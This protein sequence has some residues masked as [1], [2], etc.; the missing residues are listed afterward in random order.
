VRLD[1]VARGAAP[2]VV[3]LRLPAPEGARELRARVDGAGRALGADRVVAVRLDRPRVVDVSWTGGL[4]VEPPAVDLQPG[5][6]DG[7]LRILSFSA[8]ADGWRL[9]VEGR[10]GTTAVV[11]LHGRRPSSAAG[12]T[13]AADGDATGASIA[14]PASPE[15]FGRVEVRLRR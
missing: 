6:P 11:R 13:L 8:A 3:D 12:A 5:Q 2:L 14:I 9:V 15:P 1:P 4:A 10:A 7:G